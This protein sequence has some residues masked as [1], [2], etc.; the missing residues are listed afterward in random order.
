LRKLLDFSFNI[1]KLHRIEAGCAVENTASIKVLEKAGMTREGMKRK[2]LPIR[3]DW[4]DNYFYA[5]SEEDF[6]LNN[7]IV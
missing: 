6:M 1:L 7:P 4:K 3:G 2:K 5:I